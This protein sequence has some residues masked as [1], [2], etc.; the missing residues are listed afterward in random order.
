MTAQVE[1][2]TVPVGSTDQKHVRERKGRLAPVWNRL[3][4]FYQQTEHKKARDLTLRQYFLRWVMIF[5]VA[6]TGSLCGWLGSFVA[7][8]VNQVIETPVASLIQHILLPPTITP[9]PTNSPTPTSTSTPSPSPTPTATITPS[10]TAT[11]I[12]TGTA[13]PSVTPTPSP[14]A[15]PTGTP[16]PLPPEIRPVYF[17]ANTLELEP[18]SHAL[19]G[20]TI[21]LVDS[22][23]LSARRSQR[24]GSTDFDYLFMGFANEGYDIVQSVT[25]EPTAVWKPAAEK[26]TAPN[27]YDPQELDSQ[28]QWMG[29]H[30]VTALLVGERRSAQPSS[31]TRSACGTDWKS[32]NFAKVEITLHFTM[33]R[34]ASGEH[35]LL[36]SLPPDV[37]DPTP[38]MGEL[39][40][41]SGKAVGGN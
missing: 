22:G 10:P 20:Y 11:S 3:W 6:S 39:S 29:Y 18:L 7:A 36:L 40:A 21:R 25:A 37:K 35:T 4:A 24:A 8:P 28:A 14:S 12:P 16:T 19:D 26:Q 34:D 23:Y 9:T 2:P 5:A 33:R 38:G 13:T 31:Y 27:W 32:W 41:P 30:A 15:T 17:C 1:P